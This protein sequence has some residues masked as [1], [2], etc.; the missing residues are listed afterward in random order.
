MAF[1]LEWRR[2]RP[3]ERV[4][5]G[6]PVEDTVRAEMV[7]RVIVVVGPPCRVTEALVADHLQVRVDQNEVRMT[8]FDAVRLPQTVPRPVIVFKPFH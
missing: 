2:Q 6:T 1:Q 7:D 4:D 8:L 3:V 5:V